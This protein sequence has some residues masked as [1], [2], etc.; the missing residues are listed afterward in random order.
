M[1]SDTDQFIKELEAKRDKL[2]AKADEHR[3]RRDRLN[4]E[5]KRFAEKR[6]AL[7]DQ[8]K[9]LLREA[10][11]H[12]E[13]RNQ[14]NEQVRAA[15]ALREELNKKASAA[16]ERLNALRQER[17]PKDGNQ[18]NRLKKELKALEFKQMTTVLTPEKEKELIAALS[19]LQAMI[20][21]KEK[22]F[23]QNEEVRAAMQEAARAREE[24][25]A[26]HAL[27]GRLADEAQK[28]HDAMVEL[29]EKSDALRKEADMLQEQFVRA[30]VAA[31]EEH[32]EHV[33]LIR[34][35]HDFDKVIAGLRRR[36]RRARK[37][38][39][40]TVARKQAQEIFERFKRGEKLSTEDLMAL[41][42]KGI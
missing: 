18:L 5:T 2:N 37:A 15:K 28:E 38:R 27:V 12:K 31:D 26:Q 40:E 4:E 34:Q 22:A 6:D 16:A 17:M 21:E 29:Y 35:V 10:A 13:R 23:E 42:T 30:K 14:L 33:N 8:V 9:K 36:E 11:E 24:A 1:T 32:R 39:S 3:F 25:E 19:R 7:N 20:R 41:Q